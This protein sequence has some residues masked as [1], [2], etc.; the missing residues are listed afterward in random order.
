MVRALSEPLSQDLLEFFRADDLAKDY[1]RFWAELEEWYRDPEAQVWY[2]NWGGFL[3]PQKPPR[4]ASGKTIAGLG[5]PGTF[6]G[7]RFSRD[8]DLR[9]TTFPGGMQFYWA[10]FEGPARFDRANISGADFT[11]TTFGGP[12]SFTEA[13]LQRGSF[14]LANFKGGADFTRATLGEYAQ[15]SSAR[16]EGEGVFRSATF[17][18]RADM[19][20]VR[21]AGNAVFEDA[22]FGS[23]ASFGGTRFHG[24]ADFHRTTFQGVADFARAELQ[25]GVFFRTA[26]GGE[27]QLGVRLAEGASLEL[28]EVGSRFEG[29]EAENR[30]GV[31]RE[32]P[33]GSA[34]VRLGQMSLKGV[35]IDSVDASEWRFRRAS[36]IDRASLR[37]VSW[38][39]RGGLFRIADEEDLENPTP[40]EPP[41]PAAEVERVYRGLRGNYD[42][43]EDPEIQHRWFV[44]EMEFGRTHAR[45]FS[46]KALTRGLYKATTGYRLSAL[47]PAAWALSVTV[48]IFL[49]YMIP[50]REICPMVETSGGAGLV[51]GWHTVLRT[52]I[53][54]ASFQNVPEGIHLNGVLAEVFWLGPKFGVALLILGA[55]RA[56]IRREIPSRRD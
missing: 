29:P 21:F 16:F 38:P 31:P 41:L 48:L 36:E 46:P 24:N 55:I 47:R 34:V 54:G 14:Y 20:W 30:W 33:Q 35:A 8:A 37:N 17:H 10:V 5:G 15:F 43:G 26:V 45:P 49:L 7:A 3:F 27:L 13:N 1:R 44:T 12:A 9:R 39:S 22:F 51:C 25:R 23:D 50:S 19:S 32:A 40:N 52:M 18:G 42:R 56:L 4:G 2:A 6:V 11:G 28:V 53:F